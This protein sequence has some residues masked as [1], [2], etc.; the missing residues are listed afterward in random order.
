MDLIAKNKVWE[1][2]DQSFGKNVIANKWVFMLKRELNGEIV[3]YK[4]RL[5]VKVFTQH[6]GLDFYETFLMYVQLPSVV[7]WRRKCTWK[8]QMAL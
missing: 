2:T 8:S 3:C 1:I 7:N 5:V 6:R 4:T